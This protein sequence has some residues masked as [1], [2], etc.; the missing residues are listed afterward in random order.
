MNWTPIKEVEIWD[1]INKSY[2]RMTLEQRRIWEVIKVPPRKWSQEPF[3]NEGGGF[4]VVAIIGSSV[5][6]Y[7]DIEDGFNRSSYA[8]LG[9]INE[10]YCN[11]DNLEWQIQN[12]I[13]Q[14]RDGYDLAG[15]CGA[16]K[17]IA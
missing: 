9:Q 3:G 17:P 15:Y 1:E 6:W 13:N 10:Y 7:N 8:E 2:D 14:M 11:Q 12:L 5:I 4:W 16:P